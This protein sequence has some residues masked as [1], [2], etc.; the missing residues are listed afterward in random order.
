M[1]LD[2]SICDIKII[3]QES[4]QTFC[5]IKTVECSDQW[6]KLHSSN[7]AWLY[8]CCEKCQVRVMCPESLT[9]H[10]LRHNGIITIGQDCTVKGDTFTL[11]GHHDYRSRIKIEAPS[12][13][14]IQIPVISALNGFIN[15]TFPMHLIR[16][17][18]SEH[19]RIKE[20]INALKEASINDL[21]KHDKHHYIM[22]YVSLFLVILL[23]VIMISYYIFRRRNISNANGSNIEVQQARYTAAPPASFAPP[24]PMRQPGLNIQ[25]NPQ[26]SNIAQF[27]SISLE[28]D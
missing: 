22:I 4:D 16:N 23:S 14:N 24:K 7:D 21:S 25:N 8:S 19:E 10:R 2:Q 3:T 12:A 27:R 18:E 15:T 5:K 6:I 11:F 28:E 13:P 26:A 1:Q 17:R 20:Q 9:S